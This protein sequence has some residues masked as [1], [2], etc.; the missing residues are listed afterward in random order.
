MQ[1]HV[2]KVCKDPVP[3]YLH[4]MHHQCRSVGMPGPAQNWWGRWAGQ[5]ERERK[6]CETKAEK[7]KK[8][9][10]PISADSPFC[11]SPASVWARILLEHEPLSRELIKMPHR[12]KEKKILITSMLR[13]TTQVSK[14]KDIYVHV[15]KMYKSIVKRME[16]SHCI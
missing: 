5:G 4:R 16:W 13:N 3:T 1:R 11:H 9:K 6:P 2:R 14:G 15:G 10:R 8:G 12:Y 7:K